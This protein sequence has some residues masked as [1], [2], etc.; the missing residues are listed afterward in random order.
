MF[1]KQG[2]GTELVEFLGMK[3]FIVWPPTAH[4]LNWFADKYGLHC[5]PILKAALDIL[6]MAYCISL[7]QGDY[8]CFP[9]ARIH[10]VIIPENSEVAGIP[11]VHKSIMRGRKLGLRQKKK[12]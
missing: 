3:L 4:N 1:T 7:P 11:I 12:Q 10:A 2:S 8:L 6:Q 5:G 9:A